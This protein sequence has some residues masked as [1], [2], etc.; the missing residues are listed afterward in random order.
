MA[1]NE[2]LGNKDE[3]SQQVVHRAVIAGLVTVLA[4]CAQNAVKDVTQTC[5]I[6]RGGG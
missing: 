6:G 2:F 4:K 5:V 3:L 1:P